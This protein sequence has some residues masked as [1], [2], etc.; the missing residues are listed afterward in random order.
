MRRLF[1]VLIL[2]LILVGCATSYDHVPPGPPDYREGYRDGCNC[3][4]VQA[5]HPYYRWTK[6]VT[7]YGSSELYK[8]GWDDGRDTCRSQYEGIRRSIRRY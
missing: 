5:G 3:G 4:Y 1:F 6:N 7:K 8:Q 2:S